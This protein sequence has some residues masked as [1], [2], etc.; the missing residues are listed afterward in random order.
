MRSLAPQGKDDNIPAPLAGQLVSAALRGSEYPF[1]LLQ[2]ALERTRAEIGKTEWADL[3]RRDAR[4][5]AVPARQSATRR[6]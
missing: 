1:S 6:A 2:R 4:A 5:A 3:E